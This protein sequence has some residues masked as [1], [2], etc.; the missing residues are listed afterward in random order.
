MNVEGCVTDLLASLLA[1]HPEIA[2]RVHAQRLL[3]AIGAARTE[4]EFAVA[5][6]RWYFDEDGVP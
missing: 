6:L 1:V 3:H 4:A 2:A 5:W